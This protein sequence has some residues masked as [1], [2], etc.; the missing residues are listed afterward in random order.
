L[1]KTMTNNDNDNN[2]KE[3]NN[4][5]KHDPAMIVVPPADEKEDE[6]AL[7]LT[8]RMRVRTKQ[9]HDKSDKLVNLKLGMVLTSKDLYA[10]AISLF[11]PIY[12]E[13]E[14]LLETHKHHPQLGL[15]HPYLE[16]LRRAPNF[17]RDM[18]FMLRDSTTT[19]MKE[20]RQ[21][22]RRKMNTTNEEDEFSPPELQ[23]YI[24]NLRRLS[25]ENPIVLVAYVH[26]MY[27]A[28]MA[29]GFMI[30][31]MVQRVFSL[32]KDGNSDGV[33][34][35]E[36]DLTND[37]KKFT[38]VKGLRKEMNRIINEE[39]KL[40]PQQEEAILKESPSVFVRNNALVA[41]AKETPAFQKAT[42]RVIRLCLMVVVVPLLA[43]TSVLL[44]SRRRS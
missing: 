8:D 21:R 4:N 33:Q 43:V 17:E 9:I 24:D 10:E 38:T 36:V 27:G 26:H 42:T 20:L 19:T 29:G 23:D 12:H 22:R 25:D 14:T 35:F 11:W 32:Q 6:V 44:I 41:T 15:F 31:K 13:M 40:T 28:I 39:M 7:L 5:D 3:D 1:R 16:I 34:A 18:E 37:T 2:D 30:K